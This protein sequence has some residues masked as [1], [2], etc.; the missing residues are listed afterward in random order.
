MHKGSK[1]KY[2]G[3]SNWAYENGELYEVMGYDRELD[4]WAVMSKDGENVYAVGEDDLEEVECSEPVKVNNTPALEE[5][6]SLLF[7][8]KLW[9]K[10]KVGVAED[11]TKIVENATYSDDELFP[12][13]S[14]EGFNELNGKTEKFYLECYC[15]YEDSKSDWR[16]CY[17]ETGDSPAYPFPEG[18]R[19]VI[20][21]RLVNIP[22]E[23]SCARKAIKDEKMAAM[24]NRKI[25]EDKTSYYIIGTSLIGKREF[26]D[27]SDWLFSSAQWEPDNDGMIDMLLNGVDITKQSLDS[28]FP[29]HLKLINEIHP[30][31]TKEAMEKITDQTLSF[32]ID[33]WAEKYAVAAK[34]WSENPKW[35]SKLVSTSFV[36]NGVKRTIKPS[37]LKVSADDAFMESIQDELEKDLREY[38][39][40]DIVNCGMMD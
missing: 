33:M 26:K 1:V 23:L 12:V 30:I 20:F 34:E 11:G 27:S 39:A 38:G 36:M 9:E 18:V 2:V 29:E 6:N 22:Y 7:E 15:L 14:V 28:F 19:D 37:D 13:V 31:D 17:E 21:T 4:A 5:Y 10:V 8:Q 25:K 40:Y 3:E 35:Y 24:I 16:K 32:L